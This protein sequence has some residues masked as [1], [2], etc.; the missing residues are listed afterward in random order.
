MKNCKASVSKYV[1]KW[2]RIASVD[3]Q[4]LRDWEETVHE[5]IEQRV[6]CLKQRHVNRRKK[7]V[8]KNRVH[9]DYLNKLHE[10]NN[11]PS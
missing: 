4:V 10:N 6:R 9:L 5:C 8:L 1:K 3:R 2:A 11:S 7:H